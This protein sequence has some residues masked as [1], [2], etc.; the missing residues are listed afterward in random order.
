M[1][2]KA[3]PYICYELWGRYSAKRRENR[4]PHVPSL[5]SYWK[6]KEDLLGAGLVQ[7]NFPP[8]TEAVSGFG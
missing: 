6:K 5:H 2:K 7:C 1:Y 8:V 4:Q 3:Q